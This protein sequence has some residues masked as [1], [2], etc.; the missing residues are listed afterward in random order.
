[1]E[2]AANREL[3]EETGYRAG[4]LELLICGPASAGMSNEII[5]IFRAYDLTKVSSGGGVDDEHITV[6]LVPLD[7]IDQWL[8]QRRQEGVMVDLKFHS[9][10]YFLMNRHKQP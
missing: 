4:R 2:T 8:L 5:H 9:G 7:S 10:L 3:E 6:H 1:M